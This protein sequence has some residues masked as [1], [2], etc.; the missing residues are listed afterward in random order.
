MNTR[1]AEST[2]LDVWV[3]LRHSLWPHHNLPDLSDEARSILNSPDEV[4]F[5][6][7]HPSQGAVGFIEAAIYRPPSGPYC[8]IEGWYVIAE[9]CGH[10]HGK[11][12]IKQIEQWSLHRAIC[13]LTS[14]TD[15][16]YP[17]SPDAHARAGF[18][19]IHEMMIFAKQLQQDSETNSD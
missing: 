12:L 3:D 13:L 6:L 15:A 19:K 4:C 17:L 1:E 9:F 16:D 2:D 5:L 11:G 10:D 7:I 18:K 8:H 14:D